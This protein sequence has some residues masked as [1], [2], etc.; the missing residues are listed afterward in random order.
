MFQFLASCENKVFIRKGILDTNMTN[1]Q[2][3]Y[4]QISY[5]KPVL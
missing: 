4:Q 2:C 3:P 5:T 1:G